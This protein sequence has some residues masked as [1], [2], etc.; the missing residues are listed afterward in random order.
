MSIQMDFP[1]RELTPAASDLSLADLA[2]GL[3]LSV[4]DFITV[5]QTQTTD[6]LIHIPLNKFALTPNFDQLTKVKAR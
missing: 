4:S 2:S 3:N 5:K 1:L 6:V